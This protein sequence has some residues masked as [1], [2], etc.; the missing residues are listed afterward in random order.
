MKVAAYQAP[1]LPGGSMEALE[2]IRDRVKWCETEGVDIL[3]CPEAVL[4]GLADDAECP[5][6]FAIDVESGQL[7]ALLAPLASKSVT[8]IVGFTE[9]A[10]AGKL[11]NAA[12]VFQAGRVVGIYRKRHPAIRRSVYSAGDQSPI[13]TVGALS[14][15]IM[16]CNDSNYPE[17]ATDMAARGAKAIFLP[18]NN[19]LPP[20]RA[21]VVGSSRAVDMARA[22]DNEVMIVRA[23]VAGRTANRVS[24]GSS[25]IV[26]ARGTVLRTGA[27]LSADILVAEVGAREQEG[28]SA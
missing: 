11:Y 17:L 24:F 13:F 5:L 15:G 8:A 10:G 26:D 14:F 19:S 3:C 18:S 4:G 9:I 2:L 20:D 16:I 12:A 25:V 21:D 23:D 27:A 1:L 22:T 6:D 28:A 7:Q